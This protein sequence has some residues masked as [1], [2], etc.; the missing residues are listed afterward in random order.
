M[1]ER[2]GQPQGQPTP[3]NRSLRDL[4]VI[5]SDRPGCEPMTDA[6]RQQWAP[7]EQ[8]LLSMLESTRANAAAR[9][10]NRPAV[11]Q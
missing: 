11:N 4:A 6:E 3:R 9:C 8:G 1:P 2:I 5:G 7:L 10:T